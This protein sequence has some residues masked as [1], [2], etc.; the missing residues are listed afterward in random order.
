[1]HY[2][3]K[4]QNTPPNL[5]SREELFRWTVD[6]HNE[7]NRDNH[8]PE[9]SYAEAL[10]EVHRNATPTNDYLKHGLIFSASAISAIVL[11][12]YIASTYKN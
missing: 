5:N 1:L 9:L 12:S 4:F 6:V 7:V 11:I 2:T 8:K 3:V 10:A